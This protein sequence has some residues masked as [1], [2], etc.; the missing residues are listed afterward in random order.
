[1]DTSSAEIQVRDAELAAYHEFVAK[2]AKVCEQAAEGNLAP[3]LLH[4]PK[5]PDL[6]RVAL[7]IN[8]L[9]DMNDA[10]LRELAA[11]LE[12]AAEKKFYRR[13]LIRGMRGSF[14][15]ASQ[16]INHATQQLATDDTELSK[17]EEGR[18]TMSQTVRNVVGGLTSTASRMK[19]TAQTLSEMVGSSAN[20]ASPKGKA[21]ERAS[22]GRRDL[23]RTI[24]GLNQASQRIGGVVD[25]I[26]DIAARTNLLALN[27]AIEAA[28]AGEAGRGFAVVASEVKKLSEQTTNATG[29]INKIQAVRST[30]ELT[31][32][33]LK[34]LTVSTGELPDVSL[35]LERQSVELAAAMDEFV[36][37]NHSQS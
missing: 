24:E 28:H 4:C 1:L 16:Q 8:H 17:V 21:D 15:R 23:R 18:R 37:S 12:H 13:V 34:S 26:T 2:M 19:A 31:S 6:A 33:L 29:D 27:A 35:I 14:R 5:Q 30:A 3:R 32:Q 9:L 7:A 36:A 11:G 20:G 22:S 10:F 25:L